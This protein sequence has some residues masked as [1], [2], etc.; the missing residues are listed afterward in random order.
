MKNKN[1]GESVSVCPVNIRRKKSQRAIEPEPRTIEPV[2]INISRA[3]KLA[4]LI[5]MDRYF[6]SAQMF[7]AGDRKRAS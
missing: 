2:C 5:E 4:A 7:E 6:I 3:G 1:P